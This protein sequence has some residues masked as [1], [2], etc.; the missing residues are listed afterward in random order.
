MIRHL[1]LFICLFASLAFFTPLPA[2]AQ[3]ADPEIN[4]EEPMDQMSMNHCA[5]EAWET[6][7]KELNAQWKIS[8]ADAREAD[9]ELKSYGDDGRPGHAETLLKAQRA[10]IAFRD[11]HCDYSGFEARGGSMEP[12]LVGYCLE[13]LTLERIKQLTDPW[14]EEQ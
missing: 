8:M 4:C 11:A 2:L 9:A 14:G 13:Q 7:D 5:Y 12:M 10:W 3:Q 6:A 1:Q